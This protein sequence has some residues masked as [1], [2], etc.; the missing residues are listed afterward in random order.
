LIRFVEARMIEENN[1]TILYASPAK[2]WPVLCR[3][4]DYKY[5]HPYTRP[6]GLPVPK[7]VVQCSFRID[8][9]KD[10]FWTMNAVVA[11]CD[12][13]TR[14]VFQLRL[15]WL[16]TLEERFSMGHDPVGSKLVHS[17]RCTGLLSLLP[18]RGLRRNFQGMLKAT[19]RLLQRRL[20]RVLSKPKSSRPQVRKGFRPDR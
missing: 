18:L 7:S 10:R 13:S 17:Y 3:F 1:E 20:T 4:D 11:E 2:V 9:R 19:D 6:T 8:P 5:W 12:E 14:L 16:M 15:G